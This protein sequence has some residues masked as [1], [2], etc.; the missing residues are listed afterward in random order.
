MRAILRFLFVAS[1]LLVA[2]PAAVSA[3]V[4]GSTDIIVGRVIGPDGK[5]I[6]GARV[7][8]MSV[9]TQ[10][11]RSRTTN[12]NGQYTILFPDGGGQ[13][14]VTVRFLGFSAFTG[15]VS[16]QADEDRLE[17]NAKLTQAATQLE[18]VVVR[19][20]VSPR[21]EDNRPTP[22][23]TERTLSGEQLARLPIDPSDPNALASL[24]PGVVSVTGTDTSSAGFSVAGQR[25]DQN[26]VTLDGLTFAAGVPTEAVRS[27]R[28][29][30]NT[31][32]IARG[33]FLGGQ[34]AT[35]TR[36]GTN[37]VTGS[38]GYALRDPNLEWDAESETPSSFGSGYTQHQL[39]G[40]LG[41]AFVK[42][43]LFWFGSVQL[44]RRYDPLQAI[45]R[46][47]ATTLQGLGA[48]PDSTAR[49][50]QLLQSY[51]LPLS[52]AAVPQKR[53][54]DNA[55]AITRFDW[56]V[57]DDHSL[58]VRANWSG[59][60][61]DA[62]R[63]TP[64]AVPAHGGEQ[65]SDGVGAMVSLTSTLSSFLNELRAS[66]QKDNRTADPYLQTPEGRVRL[67]SILSDGTFSVSSLDFGGNTGLPNDGTNEQVELTDE[68]SWLS[69]GGAHRWKLG[70][71]A[72]R[73]NFST[74][75]GFNRNG[76]FIFNSL[77]DFAA[78]KPASFTR[79][80]AP[81][82]K[83]GGAINTGIYFG[84]TWRQ[85]RELQVT[86]GVRAEGSNYQ[87]RPQ[88][89]AKVDTLFGFRTD[90]F[91]TDFRVSPRV[92]FTLTLGLPAP[93]PAGQ[94]RQGGQGDAGGGR[95]GAGG[96]RGGAGGGGGGFGGFGG[97]GGGAQGGGGNQ[98]NIPSPW[99]IRGGLGE[100]RGRSSS[101]LFSSAIDAT[102]LAGSEQQLVCVGDAVPVPDW[103]SYNAG[104]AAPSEC[105]ISQ[106]PTP[107][108]SSQR[109]NVTIF[110]PNYEAP[111]ALRTSLGVSKRF[112]T[113][114]TWSLD[115]SYSMGQAQTGSFDLNLDP[116]ARFRL[117]NEGNRP[118]YV[119]SNTI[120][121][122]TGAVSFLNS[123]QHSEYARVLEVL[124]PLESKTA[125]VTA[126]LGGVSRRNMIWNFSYTWMR[127]TDQTGFSGGALGGFGGGNVGADNPNSILWGR[128]DLERKHSAVST[129]TWL[130][131]PWVDLSTVLRVSSGA[132]FTPR[133]G[134]DINGDGSTNDRAFIF[135]PSGAPDTAVANGMTRLLAN[136]PASARKCLEQQ[137]GTIASR[138]SCYGS[139]T[140]QLDLQ[141]NFRPNLG[142]S[143]QRRFTFSVQAVNPLTGLD[144]LLHGNNLHGWGQPNRADPTL[145]YVR[146]FD[147]ANNRYIYQV[148]E[149]FGD[150]AGARSALRTPFQVAITGR[151]Q[152]G[153]DRQREMLQNML[154]TM[155]GT[156]SGVG[157][158][159]LKTMLNRV[160]PNPVLTMIEMKD[161]LKLTVAQVNGLN[162][163]ADSLTKLNDAM[164]ADLQKQLEAA[165]KGKGD[166]T[167]F[168]M[169][170]QPKLQLARTNYLAAVNR[171]KT[172]LTPEQWAMLPEAVRNP[173]LNG[174]GAGRG[175]GGGQG[176]GGGQR[177]PAE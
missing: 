47:D 85:S 106:V 10:V 120:I 108:I 167:S 132:P 37:V 14:K 169:S 89:N 36:G 30:T 87:G 16:R 157:G 160:A 64:L 158:L 72:N 115:G 44:R 130:A 173:A 126:A 171:A 79:S 104:G 162:A 82:S 150:N 43:K 175:P 27:T 149:R 118:V 164:M 139:W 1:A 51:G 9:E 136:A 41:G 52:V 69:A 70:G 55:T 48:N 90:N 116:T 68:L 34:V 31:Y 18:A 42:D 142:G 84:D 73:T 28:V 93:Q 94:N 101:S 113:R 29:I 80:R 123:R 22:G 35:T 75:A 76:S 71:L 60:T 140:P 7:D 166:A 15:N 111:R 165:A 53:L 57:N 109:P 26:L 17:F 170:I 91:P 174:R 145:L 12:D 125:Q 86:Y 168:F 56:H 159:D 74:A 151:F 32:D 21:P 131:R 58:M 172:V 114:F 3:Q 163:I 100:F 96:G 4:G 25:A 45:T 105:A 67:S 46:A 128:A 110:D 152:V 23:A 39:S 133:V 138:N 49:F 78:N 33:Q 95:G 122:G 63:T 144:Q 117:A 40:G 50:L 5:P 129:L 66:W 119:P 103:T 124:S 143:I 134:S 147:A 155:N 92:G 6:K 11:T 62:F 77:S 83:E 146:G 99:I 13:Y 137:M 107:A 98:P 24:S 121:P 102:G 20:T 141:A 112:L 81:N 176:G 153:P 54:S 38:L 127:S 59:S 154:A 177:P 65:S 156:G 61:Q 97:L 148:N 19:G 2:M 161:T 135:S 8:A 88:Y